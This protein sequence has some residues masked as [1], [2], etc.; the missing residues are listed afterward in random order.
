MFVL[1]LLVIDCV[2]KVLIGNVRVK[3]KKGGLVKK[4]LYCF[5]VVL[6]LEGI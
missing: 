3:V 6:L 4:L 1:M 5:S 2:R